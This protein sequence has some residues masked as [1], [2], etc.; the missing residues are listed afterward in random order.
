MVP[1]GSSVRIVAVMRPCAL[2]AFTWP[3]SRKRSRITYASRDRIS[4]R[5]PPVCFCSSTD[6]VKKRTSSKRN[7]LGEIAQRHFERRAQVLFVE[8]RAEF[9]AQRIGHLFAHHFQA[10]GKG[11]AGAHGTRQKVERIRKLLFQLVQPLLAL[12]P[13]IQ[14]RHGCE[15]HR[16]HDARSGAR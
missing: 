13:H 9:L 8:Q 4:L 6:E 16:E 2:A 1:T 3:F 11:V 10:D 15:S 12:V 5:L 7:A 14:V